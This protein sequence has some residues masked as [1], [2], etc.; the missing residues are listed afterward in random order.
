M[1]AK[2]KS[3]R[4][5]I[6]MICLAFFICFF[7]S[8]CDKKSS[9]TV[10][11][12]DDTTTASSEEGTSQVD[13][14]SMSN[15]TA[16]AELSDYSQNGELH[17]LQV[18][19]YIDGY[20][21]DEGYYRMVPRADGSNN[22][23][24]ID[25]ATKQEVYLCSQPNCT[26]DN[27]T[28]TAWFPTVTGLHLPIPVGDRVILIHGGASGYEDILGDDSLPHI[29]IMQPDGSNRKTIY[30]FPASCSIAPLVM[31]SLASDDE[32]VYFCVE[33]YSA[34]TTTRTL[35]AVSSQTGKV[36]SLMDLS[37]VEQKI[38][39]ADGTALL[40]SYV[41]EQYDLTQNITD[42]DVEVMRY[43]LSDGAI[44]QLFSHKY[45][46]VGTCG[47][48]AYWLLSSDGVLHG[49][50]LKTGETR[51]EVSVSLPAELDL[52][53]LHCDGLFD[54]KLLVHGY[55]SPEVNAAG[56]LLYYAINT[57]DG[58]ALQLDREFVDTWDNHSPAVIATQID[59]TFMFIYGA[60]AKTIKFPFADGSTMDM[61]YNVYQY[62][63][64]K[65]SDYWNN[66]T[67]YTPVTK[68]PEE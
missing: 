36:F 59:D 13:I 64:M 9:G 60:D 29:D 50:D 58:T 46:D 35:C 32:Y 45:T 27:D 47:E 5:T 66:G 6:A 55:Y 33:N 28:C 62:A 57:E 39:G 10:T 23:C 41:S 2:L 20:A 54:G 42:I 63:F 18:D 1:E 31:D 14:G 37:G 17:L 52:T 67:N 16:F 49:Y 3:L 65:C 22:L 48:D 25:F 34:E 4:Q 38:V 51:I 7:L 30:T 40:F 26:H 24:Y 19:A 11:G 21:S 43:D 68:L 15:A 61:D 8:S 56:T 44:T 53:Q 12:I